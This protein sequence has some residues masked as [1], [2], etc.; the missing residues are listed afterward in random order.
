MSNTERALAESFLFHGLLLGLMMLM[1]ASFSPQPKKM[2]IDFFLLQPLTA[3]AGAT[4][5]QLNAETVKTVPCPQLAPP[6][7]KPRP[8]ITARVPVRHSASLRQKISPQTAEKTAV[9]KLN[10]DGNPAASH[11]GPVK[12]NKMVAASRNPAGAE[13]IE[14]SQAA[15]GPPRDTSHLRNY[16]SLIRTRIEHHKRYPLWARRHRLEGEVSV[17]FILSPG[18]KVSAVN[19]TR[20]SGRDCLDDAA[21]EAIQNA[22]PLPSPPAGV[23]TKPTAMNLTIVFK[24]A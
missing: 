3:P 12:M 6:V 1:F 23:L 2:P 7:T 19:V 22:A 16:L 24:L 20:S 18:G 17:R 9:P 5:Q 4:Q 13:H 15:V 21:K 10:N 14:S 11:T 8:K